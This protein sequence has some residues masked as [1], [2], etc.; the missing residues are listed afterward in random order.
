MNKRVLL[1]IFAVIAVIAC[2]TMSFSMSQP[3][4]D[5]EVDKNNNK[6]T[7]TTTSFSSYDFVRQIVGDKANVVYMLGPGVDA[8]SYEPSAS[9][10]VK[11]QNADIF[12]YIG[13]EMEKWT[14][15]VL[16]S[17]VLNTETTELIKV[18]D[19]VET[20]EEQKIDGAETEEEEEEEEGAFD[21]HIW[22]S[23][24]NAIK[25]L[26]Y[27][28]EKISSL[29]EENRK[30]Y[31]ENSKVYETKMIELRSKIKEITD[32][33]KRNR[34]VFG[35]KMPM[36]YFLN[37]FGLTASA[38]F[39]GCSTETEP[40]S[41]TIAYLVNKV[42]EEKIPVVF[43]IELSTGKTAKAIANETGAKATQI[44]TL[45]NI[46]KEDFENGETYV[47]LMTRNLDVLKEALQ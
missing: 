27:L 16:A 1:Y 31:E 30:F 9:D 3:H 43:Y 10:L 47:S 19:A 46:S 14:D 22:T 45:H 28:C 17:D 33:K 12:I 8:H 2:I 34:L 18:S 24:T 5:G 37:E 44:Q 20:I 15:K 39:S 32:N 40:S 41:K 25:M 6:L 7:I 4:I 35:D 38:A 21:E 11:I 23:P 36:Q 29:D 13:G 42:R 26:N